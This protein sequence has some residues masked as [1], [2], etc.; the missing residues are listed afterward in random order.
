MI[1]QL[2][3][4]YP[5]EYLFDGGDRNHPIHYDKFHRHGL[6][7]ED[8]IAEYRDHKGKRHI[9][10]TNRVAVYAPRF[11]AV[12]TVSQPIS[13]VAVHKLG[14]AELTTHGAG[15]LARTGTAM[16]LRRL[17][18][19]GVRMRSRASG[20]N[21]KS[22]QVGMDQLTPL[23]RND[24]LIN[25]FQNLAFVKTGRLKRA[26]EA[27]LAK[28]MQAATAW[29]RSRFPVIVGGLDALGEIQA[30]FQPQEIVGTDD[31]HKSPGRL[32]IV[33]MAD[34][35]SA[36]SGDVITFTIRYDNLGDRELKNIRIIDNLTPRLEYVDD[37]ATS[38]RAGRLVVEDNEEGSL[39]LKFEL[40]E[41]LKGKTGGVVTFKA[42]VR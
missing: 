6:D 26:E 19:D 28:G 40:S 18:V 33:K 27:Q 37:S 13:G 21:G 11:A 23:A 4:E 20:L 5:D 42:K 34:K 16:H 8:T 9:Q 2:A 36:Q 3:R 17:K 14:G 1:D 25:L 35:K 22:S 31:S 10:S 24:K 41:P 29:S 30:T 39:V 32:R 7:T 15:L 12:R 38:D